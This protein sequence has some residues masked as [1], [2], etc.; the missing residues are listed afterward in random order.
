MLAE[1]AGVALDRMGRVMVEPELTLPGYPNV[2][3]GDFGAL[4]RS[5]GRALPGVAQVAM[6]QG[7]YA[8]KVV[9]ARLAGKK[10]SPFTT[11]TREQWP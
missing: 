2:F 10:V 11:L 9:L 3:V 6:Q 4:C 1:R 5:T 7:V 8:A